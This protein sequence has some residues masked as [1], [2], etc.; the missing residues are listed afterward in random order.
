MQ[1]VPPKAQ[2][3]LAGLAVLKRYKKNDILTQAWEP[4][5]SL[6]D[7]GGR[8]DPRM[9]I[10]AARQAADLSFSRAGRTD[11]SESVRLSASRCRMWSR[12]RQIQRSFA[13]KGR[14]FIG[15]AFSHPQLVINIIEILGQAL[16]SSN[17]RISG[18]AGEKSGP[19]TQ[20]GAVPTCPK[21]LVPGLTS[22]R[23]KSPIWA[24]TT[25]ESALR[26][27]SDFAPKRHHRKKARANPCCQTRSPERPPFRRLMAL[28]PSDFCNA[29]DSFFLSALKFQQSEMLD[30]E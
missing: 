22:P 23:W 17:S 28:K 18:H 1:G 26:V 20:T 25:T 24:S 14:I 3:E 10:F 4:S 5:D 2:E 7:R 6:H 29:G 13:L 30:K 16:D 12:R 19:A 15:V 11:Q 9:Q 21:N 8:D 27:L